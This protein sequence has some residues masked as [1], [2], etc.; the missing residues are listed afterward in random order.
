VKDHPP[1]EKPWLTR[2]ENAATTKFDFSTNT[3]F[4]F[5]G[6]MFLAEFGSGTPLTAKGDNLNGYTVIRIDPHRKEMQPF[7]SNKKK[8]PSGNEYVSTQGP[9]HPVEAKFS[10]NGDVLYVVDIGVI[11]F[12][13]AGAGPFPVPSPGT[14]VIWRIT[15][16]GTTASGPPS[17]LSAMPP[18]T[19]K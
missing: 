17:N 16:E 7:L 2:P 18:E 9:R 10:P 12:Q 11:G 14:G 8:G 13:L 15:K 6:Q 1:V 3:S 5:K 4:G 19:I